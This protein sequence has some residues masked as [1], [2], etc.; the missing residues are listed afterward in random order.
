MPDVP[1]VPALSAVPAV[2]ALGSPFGCPP[3]R[4]RLSGTASCGESSELQE[5]LTAPMRR[6]ELSLDKVVV[7]EAAQVPASRFLVCLSLDFSSSSQPPL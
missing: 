2:P 1:T 6:P 3:L 4:S 5:R 7:D